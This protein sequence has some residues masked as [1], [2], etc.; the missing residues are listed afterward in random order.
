MFLIQAFP[1]S[2]S[3]DLPCESRLQ[4]LN[5][6]SSQILLKRCQKEDACYF[7]IVNS[8]DEIK[9]QIRAEYRKE[10]GF[11]SDVWKR[12]KRLGAEGDTGT[13]TSSSGIASAHKSAF[14]RTSQCT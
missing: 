11:K 6:I 8:L 4:C 13:A 9:L 2:L 12:M 5:A 10:V 7:D 14:S 1:S 3:R